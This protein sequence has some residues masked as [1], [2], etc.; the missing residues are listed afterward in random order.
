MKRLI[1]TAACAIATCVAVMTH[2]APLSEA[3]RAELSAHAMDQSLPIEERVA[4]IKKTVSRHAQ[5]GWH[6]A[7]S[8]HLCMGYCW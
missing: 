5:C 7:N 6:S 4:T 8:H 3:K 2:A 1:T